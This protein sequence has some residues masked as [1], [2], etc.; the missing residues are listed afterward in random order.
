MH[1]VSGTRNRATAIYRLSMK[2]MSP[3]QNRA[4]RAS[5]R[6]THL[7][8]KVSSGS[9]ISLSNEYC[10]LLCFKSRCSPR[11]F[12]NIEVK[13]LSPFPSRLSPTGR[14]WQDALQLEMA[15][16]TTRAQCIPPVLPKLRSEQ[17][18]C[19]FHDGQA[20]SWK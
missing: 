10:K 6:L 7:R 17:P 20:H 15:C 5:D 14:C 16:P 1:I 4:S 12:R 9:N 3:L 13:L 11:Y 2:T 19:S 8:R 18:T